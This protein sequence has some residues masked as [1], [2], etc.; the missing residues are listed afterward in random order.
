MQ[1][2]DVD[3][4]ETVDNLES[5]AR[6]LVAA[7]E[8]EWEPAGLD[9]HRTVRPVRTA[10]VTQV[11]QPVYK[12]LVARWKKYEPAMADLFAALPVNEFPSSIT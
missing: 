11:W 9:F 12:Q 4:E 8:L 1:I 2:L 5:V 6:R 3:Y 10:S 7:C